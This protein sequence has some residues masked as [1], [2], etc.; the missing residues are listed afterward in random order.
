MSPVPH[1]LSLSL[2]S[3]CVSTQESKPAVYTDCLEPGQHGGF[4]TGE[5]IPAFERTLSHLQSISS[6]TTESLAT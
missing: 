2:C 3:E 6:V 1:V 5:H 4:G